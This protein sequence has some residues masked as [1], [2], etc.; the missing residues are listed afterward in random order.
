MATSR[1]SSESGWI[2]GAFVFSGRPD[3]TWPITAE[4]AERIEGI[5]DSLDP[6]E[7]PLPSPD[8]LGYRGCFVRDTAGRTWTAFGGAVTQSG[9]GSSESR[10]D[11]ARAFELTTLASA[12]EGTL[13]PSLVP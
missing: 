4:I 7:G 5:W 3:P 9:N 2:A 11:D 10:R 13:P 12:P 8:A 6:W 1:S